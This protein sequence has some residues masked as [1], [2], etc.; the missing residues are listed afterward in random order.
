[1]NYNPI[2]QE[3]LSA[4]DSIHKEARNLGWIDANKINRILRNSNAPR[5]K[6]L[7]W[8]TLDR[9]HQSIRVNDYTKEAAGIFW[10]GQPGESTY[11]CLLCG[12]FEF[13]D[14]DIQEVR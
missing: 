4:R 2:V 8:F 10:P 6:R 1:M 14:L 12:E 9:D 3:I 13:F 7:H 11:I 5:C